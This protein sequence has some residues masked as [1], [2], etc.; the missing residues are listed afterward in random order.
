M[1]P[2]EVHQ[3]GRPG[4]KN[5]IGHPLLIIPD[6]WLAQAVRGRAEHAGLKYSLD[7]VVSMHHNFI[8]LLQPDSAEIIGDLAEGLVVA[9]Y[10]PDRV[11]EAVGSRDARRIYVAVQFHPEFE[12]TLSWATG[13]FSYIVAGSTRDAAV[14]RSLF[15]SFREDISAWLW[16]RGRS[17][18]ELPTTGSS[19]WAR[20]DGHSSEEGRS[21]DELSRT[22]LNATHAG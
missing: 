19:E 17:L 11:I 8:G 20:V 4:S 22:S 1:P 10:S 2:L 3:R 15:D 6:S 14:A 21:T 16:L 9:G 13:I 7:S 18:H 12:R 5:R